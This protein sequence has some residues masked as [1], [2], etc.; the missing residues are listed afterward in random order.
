MPENANAADH[1]FAEKLPGC[2]P[3]VTKTCEQELMPRRKNRRS[4]STAPGVVECQKPAS[5]RRKPPGSTNSLRARAI[6]H[7]RS[8]DLDYGKVHRTRRLILAAVRFWELRRGIPTTVWSG[9]NDDQRD[10]TCEYS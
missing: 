6:L 2:H 5:K 8:S 1:H 3:V 10:W 9:V 4:D 7:D